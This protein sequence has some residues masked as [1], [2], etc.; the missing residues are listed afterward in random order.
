MRHSLGHYCSNECK[1]GARNSNHPGPFPRP[2]KLACRRDAF[3]PSETDQSTRLTSN[4]CARVSNDR[5][6]RRKQAPAWLRADLA[7]WTKLAD[8]A[9][10]HGRIGQTLQHWQTDADLAGIR[11]SEAVTTLPADE[12]EACKKA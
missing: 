11:D 1:G 2:R 9:K 6:R 5:T 3:N 8:D 10:K 12:Q 7:A 4:L